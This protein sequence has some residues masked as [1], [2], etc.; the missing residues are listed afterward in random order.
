MEIIF[1]PCWVG[2]K[3]FEDLLVRHNPAK[4]KDRQINIKFPLGCSLL[5]HVVT[6]VLSLLN[7][8]AFAG[9]EVNVTFN[10]DLLG[11]LDR[12]GFFNVLDPRINISP[13][14]PTL[15]THDIYFGENKN[16]LEIS[17]LPPGAECGVKDLP[18]QLAERLVSVLS[19]TGK[20]PKS[21]STEMF[22]VFSELISNYF[23]HSE[24]KIPGYVVAQT[25]SGTKKLRVAVSDSGLGIINTIRRDR[26][27]EFKNKTDSELVVDI[28]NEGISR[29][30]SGVG[31]SC[32]LS[33]LGQISLKYSADLIVRMPGSQVYLKPGKSKLEKNMAYL[34]S[35]LGDMGGS[36]LCFTFPLD[37]SGSLCYTDSK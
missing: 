15:S 37:K 11:Y 7:Q 36:H 34:Q 22:T 31:R 20:L 33:R 21:F 28:F 17:S 5:I 8:L 24:S 9:K 25:Y 30:G 4:N 12:M 3:P 10:R 19:P 1:P 6:R 35:N 23:E 29:F 14:R 26:A 27:L 16:L 2:T 32:G 13:S 18:G